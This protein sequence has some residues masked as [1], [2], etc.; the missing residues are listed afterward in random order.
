MK[1]LF[2][3]LFFAFIASG[4][5]DK[6]ANKPVRKSDGTL[7]TTADNAPPKDVTL[8]Y[9]L[10]K[11]QHL[12]YRVVSTN[13][14]S[15]SI[16]SDTTMSQKVK[17]TVTYLMDIDVKDVDQEKVMELQVTLKS[18]SLTAEAG[19]NKV[20]YQSGKQLSKEDKM[21]FGQYE[22][23]INSPFS[24]RLDPKG[25]IREIY[26]VDRIVNKFL[27]MQGLQDSVNQQQK[28]QLQMSIAEGE[29]KPLIQQV[30]RSLPKKTV[31]KD[32]SWQFSYPARLGIFEIENIAKYRLAG[33]EKL[34]DQ[35]L[36]AIDAGLDIIPKGKTKFSE[37]GINYDFKKPQA[38]G[39]GR[40][41]FNLEKGC[42]QQ[43]KTSTKLVMSLT[44]QMPNS[45]RGPMKATRND[46]MET[47]NT[48]E[49]L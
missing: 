38:S 18:I 13:N 48:V 3:L 46:V 35:R 5:G 40:I 16:T 22:A 34:G 10:Q 6:E 4:C 41:Y 15:Q 20:T 39:N 14:S 27:N 43:S 28:N 21:K 1:K 37:R 12:S 26:Q 45:P 42:I 25:E 23:F 2:I 36:A 8:N 29:L 7:N 47:T 49:L 32:S 19:K 17:Q 31:A 11:N 44:M 33:F 24:V 9:S 30:F